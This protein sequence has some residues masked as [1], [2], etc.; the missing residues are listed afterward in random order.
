MMTLDKLVKSR[1]SKPYSLPVKVLIAWLGVT[2]NYKTK[3]GEL[4][5]STVVGIVDKDTAMK[6][7]VYDSSKL[8]QMAVGTTVLLTNYIYKSEQYVKLDY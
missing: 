6:A 8:A 7:V 4:K 1:A 2:S 5:E 3:K